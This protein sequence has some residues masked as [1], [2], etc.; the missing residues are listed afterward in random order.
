MNADH[1]D[2][3][4]CPSCEILRND[5]RLNAVVN[6]IRRMIDSDEKAHDKPPATLPLSV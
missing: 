5:H 4:P 2:V 3:C 1:V 6:E